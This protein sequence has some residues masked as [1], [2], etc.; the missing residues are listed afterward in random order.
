M[1]VANLDNVG[2]IEAL[3]YISL[4]S[5]GWQF[6]WINDILFNLFNGKEITCIDLDAFEYGTISSFSNDLS[7]FL[8]R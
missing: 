4:S 8:H 3:Q 6:I 5:N 7:N 2:V 1:N